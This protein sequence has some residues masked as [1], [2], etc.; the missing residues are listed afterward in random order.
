M[1]EQLH[2]ESFADCLHQSFRVVHGGAEVLDLR[3][4]QVHE[5]LKS[6]RQESFSIVFHGPASPFVPQGT[7]HLQNEKLGGLDLFLVPIGRDG[8]GFQ[9][10][11]VFNRLIPAG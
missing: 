8:N 1:L 10:E 5:Y 11:A 4:T 3:L 2:R 9:Y 6:A 7:Y